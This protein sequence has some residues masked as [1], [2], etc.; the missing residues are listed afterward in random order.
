MYRRRRRRICLGCEERTGATDTCAP[1]WYHER[2]CDRD[3]TLHYPNEYHSADRHP[4]ANDD[5]A[6]QGFQ[7]FDRQ[8]A[9]LR[10][11][12]WVR[13]IGYYW[14]CDCNSNP[15]VSTSHTDPYSDAYPYSTDGHWSKRRNL[16]YHT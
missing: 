1:A 2:H 13:G 3:A 9:A 5:D 6:L 8:F 4:V 7:G 10:L 12:G 15:Y 14:R 16:F 11:V